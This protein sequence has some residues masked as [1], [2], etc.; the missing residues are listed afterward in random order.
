M[1]K[2]S[3]I[4]PCYN[5]SKTI[6]LLLEKLLSLDLNLQIIVVDDGSKDQSKDIIKK[7][8]NNK[9]ILPIFYNFNKGKGFAIRQAQEKVTGDIVI[10]Q[11]ADLEYN[12][13]DYFSLI[14]PIINNEYRVVYGSRVLNKNLFENLKNFSHW[15]RIIGNIFLTRFSNIINKQKLTDAHTCYKV[16]DSRIF[17]EIDLKEDG[18]SFCP[19]ITTKISN[20][21]IKIKEVPISY[22]GR[23]YSEGKKIKS[24]DGILA[25]LTIL[26]Y[27]FF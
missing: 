11:D 26:K 17:K 25:I 8:E 1:V 24:I 5:E 6:G 20:M 18:F 22:N 15:I 2:I 10:I 14:K 16:F 3:V 27:K 23:D 21:K 4:I 12:P 7:Y 19:E 13:E 9:K